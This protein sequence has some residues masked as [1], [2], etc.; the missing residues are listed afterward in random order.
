MYS[1]RSAST[2]ARR[3]RKVR[4]CWGDEGMTLPAVAYGPGRA[5]GTV[6][7]LFTRRTAQRVLT[8]TVEN[9][10]WG[11]EHDYL[12]EKD[13]F[14]FRWEGDRVIGEGGPDE[15]YRFSIRPKQG[16]YALFKDDWR[17]VTPPLP[18]RVPGARGLLRYLERPR[19]FGGL[20]TRWIF[21][22]VPR[23]VLVEALRLA[24]SMPASA[25]TRIVLAGILME[26]GGE[27]GAWAAEVK[28]GDP[29]PWVRD[30]MFIP[31]RKAPR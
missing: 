29:D 9:V 12:D 28:A 22:H 15:R 19:P 21:E 27:A 11:I 10:R 14:S 23:A 18:R 8:L 26:G 20:H 5:D 13:A 4:V 24:V 17:E 25:R 7:A 2:P 30:A 3:Q 16:R 31:L 6:A 1:T